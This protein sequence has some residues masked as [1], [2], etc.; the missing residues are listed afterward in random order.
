MKAD[1]QKEH[2]WLKKLLGEWRSE[3]EMS[4]EPGKD[5]ELFVGTDTVH[6]VGE[7]WIQA[8]SK[9][10]MPGGGEAQ[11][12]MTLGYDPDERQFVGTFIGS[13]MTYLWVYNSGE[14][15]TSE[16]V[17]T[18]HCEG[19]AFDNPGQ[20]TRFKDVIEFINDNERTL[21]G[22]M[23]DKDG[24]WQQLMVVKYTRRK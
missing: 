20:K 5:P 23:L 2:L 24:Q 1:P 17:L 8:V 6:T 16:R 18:L 9:G 3:C 21:T 22:N 19:P 13:M 7:I 10:P 15:D 11:T 4:L 12:I 14:L